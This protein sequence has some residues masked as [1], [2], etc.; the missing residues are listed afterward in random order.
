MA[1]SAAFLWVSLRHAGVINETIGYKLSG[2]YFQGDDWEEGRSKEDLNGLGEPVFDAYG[3]SGEFRVDY[4]PNDD[5]TTIFNTGFT[6]TTGME[7]TGLGAGQGKNWTYGY[8]QGRFI[9]KDLF[10]QAFWNT[11]DAGD[12]YTLR[13]GLPVVDKSSLY[14]GQIQ[15][16]YSL[17]ERQRFTYGMDLLLTRP[18]TEETINGINEFDDDINEVGA[19]LQ[20]ETKIIPQL[21]FIAAARGDYHNHLD[22]LVFSPRAALALQPNDDHSLRLTYNRAFSTP[23]ASNLF[24]DRMGVP[25][26]YGLGS[27]FEPILGF[28]PNI[29]I[30]AQGPGSETGF[31]FKR[32][33]AGRPLFRSPF[34]PVAELPAD[35]Q[36]PL[37]DPRGTNLMWSIG[38]RSSHGWGAARF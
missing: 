5:L 28:S 12:T 19:Y 37:D 3:A 34:S 4:K 27:N 29:D 9:Y 11:S 33:A 10:A 25:D 38:A 22:N 36:L 31:T 6:Q 26:A 23:T 8:A 17:G 16:G 24:L 20:S 15:H 30:R 7:L 35:A 32:D 18:D 2:R 13:D 14:V 1:A 21:K